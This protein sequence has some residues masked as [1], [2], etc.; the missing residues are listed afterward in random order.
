VGL[1]RADAVQET[2]LSSDVVAARTRLRRELVGALLPP[3]APD[4]A[5]LGSSARSG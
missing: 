5:A 1:D 4:P 3:E 2:R